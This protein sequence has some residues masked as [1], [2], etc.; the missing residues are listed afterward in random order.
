[1]IPLYALAGLG[2][3]AVALTPIAIVRSFPAAVRFSG[4]SFSY[5]VAYAVVGGVTPLIVVWLVQFDR[6]APAYYMA[7]VTILGI[8]AVMLA[9]QAD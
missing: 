5:N 9:P 4:F 8:A 3:G 2:A 1:L 6:M 7:A